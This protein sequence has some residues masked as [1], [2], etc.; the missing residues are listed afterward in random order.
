MAQPS[1]DPAKHFPVTWEELHRHAKALSWRVA[2]KG[3]WKGIVAITR[4]GLVRPPWWRAS[5]TSA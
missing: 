1:A 2:D 5:W 4:G 3:P